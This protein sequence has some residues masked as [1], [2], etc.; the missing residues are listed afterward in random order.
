ML[1]TVQ[2]RPAAAY[3]RKSPPRVHSKETRQDKCVGRRYLETLG[4]PNRCKTTK[5]S[6]LY[7]FK[8][9][10]MAQD[11]LTLKV[12]VVLRILGKYSSGQTRDAHTYSQEMEQMSQF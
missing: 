10:P 5:L 9:I 3:A 12:S 2:C 6:P 1:C 8:S 7:Q 11:S 4:A